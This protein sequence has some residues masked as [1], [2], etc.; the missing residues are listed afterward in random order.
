MGAIDQIQAKVPA[1]WQMYFEIILYRL[2][3]LSTRLVKKLIKLQPLF[4]VMQ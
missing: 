1:V 4:Q 3:M 2:L